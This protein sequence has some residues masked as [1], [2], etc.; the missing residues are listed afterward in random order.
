MVE[1]MSLKVESTSYHHHHHHQD[2]GADGGGGSGEKGTRFLGTRA[3]AI[4]NRW[5]IDN[6]GYP[7]PNE[8]TTDW[9]AR[10][11]G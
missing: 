3:V 2:G 9:L 1:K 7:Y 8:S 4:L 6:Q 11:A 10:Q 5:F